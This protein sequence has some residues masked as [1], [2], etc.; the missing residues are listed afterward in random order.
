ML[1][2]PTRKSLCLILVIIRC[3]E[4][5]RNSVFGRSTRPS[6][7]KLPQREGKPVLAS[8]TASWSVP[9]PRRGTI[10][11]SNFPA[12]SSTL[13]YPGSISFTVETNFCRLLTKLGNKALFGDITFKKGLQSMEQE[14]R[15][16]SIICFAAECG[17]S[18][19]PYHPN[20]GTFY[21]LSESP[22]IIF[23]VL[24]LWHGIGA[25][26]DRGFL[27][28][29]IALKDGLYLMVFFHEA[30]SSPG[31]RYSSGKHPMCAFRKAL[32]RLVINSKPCE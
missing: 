19:V 2:A 1:Y 18:T 32:R 7:R 4:R 26:N 16:L 28:C 8:S 21:L 10:P 27:A 29:H 15:H 5:V 12:I 11:I 31:L 20:I 30:C 9:S 25:K 13:L 6:A 14:D 17:L 22:G 3:P 24:K 23:E